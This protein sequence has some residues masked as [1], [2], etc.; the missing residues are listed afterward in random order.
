MN[1]IH[2]IKTQQTKCR[3]NKKK[4]V[5]TAQNPLESTVTSR[6]KQHEQ[7]YNYVVKVLAGTAWRGQKTSARGEESKQEANPPCT[8]P[9]S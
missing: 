7:F 6:L 8:Q 5:T 4:R 3:R 9:Q 2:K 1:V